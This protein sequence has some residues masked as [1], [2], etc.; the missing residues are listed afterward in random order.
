[1]EPSYR[2][3]LYISSIA[4]L[5]FV[6][7]SSA[8]QESNT[9][10]VYSNLC[11]GLGMT[12]GG[13][14]ASAEAGIKHF[15]A[16]ASFGYAPPTVDGLVI[17]D[18]SFNYH[19]GMRYYLNVGSNLI[20]P[21]VGLSYG[22]ITNYYDQRIGNRNYLQTVDGLC[23]QIGVQ[24]YSTEGIVVNF[25]LAMSGAALVTHQSVHPYFFNFYL[26]PCI[27]IG[28]D[29]SRIYNRDRGERIRNNEISPFE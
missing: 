9:P 1:M 11:A 16:F 3:F 12:Y 18:P 29:L 24:F 28:Y 19:F 13:Y 26:R 4:V 6:Q 21:R 23:G 10:S 25:D 8:A 15:S 2:R 27:G 20:F 14:G 17:I 5:L 22:W 7:Y